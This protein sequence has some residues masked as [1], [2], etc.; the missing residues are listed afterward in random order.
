MDGIIFSI[1]Y[2]FIYILFI[3]DILRN[4]YTKKYKHVYDT[5]KGKYVIEIIKDEKTT[6]ELWVILAIIIASLIPVIRIVLFVFTVP[7]LCMI[8]CKEYRDDDDLCKCYLGDNSIVKKI[9]KFFRKPII[10]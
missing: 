9:I 3:F 6:I 2:S 5:K 8:F 1:I 10:K 4:I 7:V